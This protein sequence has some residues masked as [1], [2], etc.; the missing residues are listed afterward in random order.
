MHVGLAADRD[1]NVTQDAV[2]E[3]ERHAG[4]DPER[5]VAFYK[6]VFGWQFTK[7]VGPMELKQ[8]DFPAA[9]AQLLAKLENTAEVWRER[10]SS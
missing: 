2:D 7:W 6:K 1:A 8:Y 10:A 4:S 9:D 3:A 5:A